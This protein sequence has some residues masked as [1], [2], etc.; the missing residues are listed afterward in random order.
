[1]REERETSVREEHEREEK[2]RVV[3][4]ATWWRNQIDHGGR[5]VEVVGYAA[6]A[7]CVVACT[8]SALSSRCSS[9]P[10]TT[11]INH[12]H[13]PPSLLILKF[14]QIL[15]T[16]PPRSP[17]NSSPQLIHSSSPLYPPNTS[18]HASGDRNH[19]ILLQNC[20]FGTRTRFQRNRSIRKAPPARF[21]HVTHIFLMLL[22]TPI[23]RHIQ[24]QC[25][26]RNR[27]FAWGVLDITLSRARQY[28]TQC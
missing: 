7:E 26:Q 22:L 24:K 20:I 6:A 8:C 12:C 14:I 2:R 15:P 4:K 25:D 18:H 27:N 19:R 13:R 3:V 9:S 11:T 16:T 21:T 5:E 17:D 28:Q 23:C 10:T 1:M